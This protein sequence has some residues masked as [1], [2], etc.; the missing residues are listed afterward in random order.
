M[1]AVVATLGPLRIVFLGER[2]LTQSHKE[3]GR[4][5]WT[6]KAS[7]DPVK[8]WCFFETIMPKSFASRCLVAPPQHTSRCLSPSLQVCCGLVTIL[9]ALMA[10]DRDDSL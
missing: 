6:L 7:G 3:L 5:G 1:R 9:A 10:V 2:F 4:T 8:L